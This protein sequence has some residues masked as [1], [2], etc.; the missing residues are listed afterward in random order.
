MAAKKKESILFENS[1]LEELQIELSRDLT[2]IKA[3]RE[4]VVR[5]SFRAICEKADDAFVEIEGKEYPVVN[6][7][8][9]GLGIQ[10]P[11]DSIFSR[12]DELPEIIFSYRGR[13]TTLK[14][15]VVHVSMEAEKIFLCGI[16]LVKMSEKQEKLLLQIVQQQRLAMFGRE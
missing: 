10:L 15:C 5:R 1:D 11:N 8:N 14:G 3:V 9:K 6:I 4:E 2:K 12:G 13:K 16:S 7:G